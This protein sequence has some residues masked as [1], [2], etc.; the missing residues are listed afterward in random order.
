MVIASLTNTRWAAR[1]IVLHL[2]SSHPRRPV[3][4]REDQNVP[5][6]FRH[7]AHADSPPIAMEESLDKSQSR[8]VYIN[9]TMWYSSNFPKEEFQLLGH[10]RGG[11][12]L[13]DGPALVLLASTQDHVA[14]VV[15]L[16]KKQKISK[17][18][19]VQR[20]SDAQKNLRK[21]VQNITRYTK[22][23]EHGCS[24]LSLFCVKSGEA[25]IPIFCPSSTSED[26]G[27]AAMASLELQVDSIRVHLHGRS[28]GVTSVLLT[29]TGW[30]HDL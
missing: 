20:W 26:A 16:I 30:A 14:F 5:R 13:R 19:V 10:S 21:D 8:P 23:V 25:N 18:N 24:C 29:S 2:I 7:Q 3:P 28:I 22:I 12:C 15:K 9:R 6:A 27:V 11:C 4:K 17:T 1:W